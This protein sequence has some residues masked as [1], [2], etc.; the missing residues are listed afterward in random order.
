MQ[1]PSHDGARSVLAKFRV[2][3]GGVKGNQVHC[4]PLTSSSD[5][6]SFRLYGQFL[7]GP[8]GNGI[9]FNKFFGYM[10]EISDIWSINF[11]GEF[12]A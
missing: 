1:R 10:V 12:K 8:E 3:T 6:W 2:R 5:I 9:S 11:Y 4:V 7:A